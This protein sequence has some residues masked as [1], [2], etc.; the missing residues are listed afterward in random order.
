MNDVI[1]KQEPVFSYQIATETAA[2]IAQIKDKTISAELVRSVFSLAVAQ[3]KI[4]GVDAKSGALES[5]LEILQ[6]KGILSIE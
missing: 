5:A 4:D 3:P 6:E 1:Q 2:Q